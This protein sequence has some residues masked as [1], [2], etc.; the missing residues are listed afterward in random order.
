MTLVPCYSDNYAYLLSSPDRA[1]V[2]VVDA[3]ET[4]PLESMLDGRRLAAI[5]STHHHPDHV[6]GNEDLAAQHAG[7]VV[8]GHGTELTDGHRIPAQTV[9]LS[10]GEEFS[11]LGQRVI[12]FHVPGHT[13]TAVAYYFPDEGMVFT[14]DTMFGAGC[15]R[16]FEG[17]ASQL[18]ASLQRLCGLPPS[19]R[20]HSGHE[21]L[22]RNLRFARHLEPDHAPT[23][24]RELD[25][26]RRREQGQPCEPSTLAIELLT[27][28]FVRCEVA[29]VQLA[30]AT[31]PVE[32]GDVNTGQ[33]SSVE[34]FAR[35]RRW[36]NT[37]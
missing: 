2:V 21:Y 3:C 9:G 12:A 20:V 33:L 31:R 13:L 5:L 8:C 10:D 37:F 28:P 25:C 32:M 24:D 35:L 4:A 27:N 19:T 7:L 23:K 6:G 29:A 15:G 14:G 16:L 26:L 1:E 22:A 11:V 36:R 30:V 34:V 18:H 17:T